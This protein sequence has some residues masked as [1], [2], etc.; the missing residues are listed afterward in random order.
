MSERKMIWKEVTSF[1]PDGDTLKVIKK[2]IERLID[3]YGE[4]AQI[5]E[6]CREYSDSRY[7]SVQVQLP[8][9]DKQYE[10][11]LNQ[12]ERWKNQRE[13]QERAEFE[14]LSAK[15]KDQK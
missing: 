2:E 10:E 8:E 13:A 15:F 11:R 7:L 3:A 6:E 4:N 1:Y 9:S 5:S 12:E 14:R